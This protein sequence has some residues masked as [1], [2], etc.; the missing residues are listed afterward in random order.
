MKKNFGVAIITLQSLL[1]FFTTTVPAY[2]QNKALTL[3]LHNAPLV[4]I[5]DSIQKQTSYRFSYNLSL[6]SFLQQNRVTINVVN[7][8]VE[9]ILPLIFSGKDITY[10][11]VDNVIL[12]SKR[13]APAAANASSTELMQTVKGKVVDKESRSPLANVSITLTGASTTKGVITDSSGLFSLKLPVGRQS[14]LF[15]YVGYQE[16]VVADVEVISGKETFLTIGLQESAEKMKAVVVSAADRK[17]RTLNSMATVSAQ[18]VTPEDA[19][20]YAAGYNDPARM[21]SALAGVL[22]GGNGRNN[23][24]VRGNSPAGLLWRLEGIEIPAPNHF[25]RGQGDGGGLFNLVGSNMLANFDFFTGAFPAEYGNALAGI[26]DLNLRKGNSD[27]AEYGIQAGVIG[28]EISL[29][30]PLSKNKK[31]SYLLNYR[32]GNLQFLNKAGIIHLPN[33]QKPPVFQDMGLH[34]NLPTSKAGEFALFGIGGASTTGYYSTKD[35]MLWRHDPDARLDKNE[36]HKLGVLG[37]KHTLLLRNKKTNLQSILAYSYQSDR[38]VNNELDNTYSFKP[39]DSGQ[40]NYSIL[41]F[42]TTLNHKFNAASVIRT[43]VIYSQYF[44]NIF[45]TKP[46]RN[47]VSQPFLNEHGNTASIQAF[48]QWKYRLLPRLEVNSGVHATA[49]LL[50]NNYVIEPRFG[51]KWRT[52]STSVISYGFGMHSRIE[53]ISMY[54]AKTIDAGGAVSQANLNLKLTQAMHHV[55]GYSQSLT[56][57]LRIKAELY[58]QYLYHVPV[59]DNVSSTY[60]I[61]NN[62]YGITDSAYTSKG[63]GYN[64]GIELTLEKSFSDNYYL[65]LTG[66]V[67]DSKYKPANGQ[68]YNTRFNTNY[69]VNALAGKEFKTGRFKQ[70][71]FSINFRAT[72]HGGFR[73]SPGEAA[74][75]SNGLTY[76]TFPAEK[77]YSQHTGRYMRYDAGFKFRKNNRRYSWILSLDVQDITNRQNVL[78]YEPQ[79]SPDNRIH[80]DPTVTDPGIIPIL[81]LKVEF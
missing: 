76:F 28:S 59:V 13:E 19:S 23:I 69:L 30:G 26:M 48:F 46:D 49:F 5:I 2:A 42:T 55:L 21:V 67:Y 35:S 22:S 45:A 39:K 47:G 14:L 40:Y 17:D 54:F 52:G 79:L 4:I 70:N 62:L 11:V 73:Y 27:K 60:S 1:L 61:L 56:K 44:F 15:T 31:S 68:T 75:N 77:T 7:K 16:Q 10:K 71:V 20:R 66:T 6:A 33:D 12:L 25:S 8:P 3:K 43:G 36:Y 53:P 50:N 81:N 9:K 74:Q 32:Y 34:V 65:L 63:K 51:A 24:I 64:K 58:Y 29:E 37:I 41:R 18:M 38:Q 57:N 72:T 80:L 78:E